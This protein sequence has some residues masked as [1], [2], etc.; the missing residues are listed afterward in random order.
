MRIPRRADVDEVDIVPLEDASPVGFDV[1]PAELVSGRARPLLVAPDEHSH[2]WIKRQIEEPGRY[3]PPLGVGSAHER[4]ADHGYPEPPLTLAPRCI[5]LCEFRGRCRGYEGTG[6]RRCAGR[7]PRR[8]TDT[9]G[10]ECRVDV[11]V[12]VVTGHDGRV[13]PDE[14][15]HLVLDEVGHGLLLTEEASDAHAIGGLGGRVD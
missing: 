6:Q 4:V 15:G 2:F 5:S 13:Q 10:L 14:A 11:F 12:D 3:A 9:S 1:A 7:A 8:T